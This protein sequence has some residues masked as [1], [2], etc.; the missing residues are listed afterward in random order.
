[1]EEVPVDS[2]EPEDPE[3]P[4]ED[5]DSEDPFEDEPLDEEPEVALLSVR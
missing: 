3:D 4:V 5:V 2:E 1:M